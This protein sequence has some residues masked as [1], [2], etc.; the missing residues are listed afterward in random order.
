MDIKQLGDK[1]ISL[2]K[3]YKFVV[4]ILLIGIILMLLP[5]A[6]TNNESN[7]PAVQ[8][9]PVF[10]DPTEELQNLLAQ[11]KGA[12]KVRLMLTVS[13][14]EKYIYQ[15]DRDETV[16]GETSTVRVETIILTDS[17]RNQGGMVQQI[18]APQ[19]RGAV[20]VCQGADDPKVKLAIMEAVK[21]MTGLGYDRIS[22]LK[23]K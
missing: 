7:A 22:V 3:K 18:L 13:G 4:L 20:V 6:N 8:S 14:G 9:Q 17:N 23:M 21:N 19:Y 10:S 1:G 16:S 12:G 2:I 5:A 11:I 15:T